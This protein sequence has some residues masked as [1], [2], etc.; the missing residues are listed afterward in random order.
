VLQCGAVWCSVVQCGAGGA[1]WR[2][3]LLRLEGVPNEEVCGVSRTP[4]GKWQKEPSV[5]PRTT[6]LQQFV[7]VCCSALQ[8]VV[9]CNVVQ[10]VTV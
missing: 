8:Y 2:R 5:V 4:H 9:W 1:G 10:C 3:V 7:A 6:A